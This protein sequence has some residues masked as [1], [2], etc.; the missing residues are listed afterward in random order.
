M[1]QLSHSQGEPRRQVD[2]GLGTVRSLNAN[3]LDLKRGIRDNCGPQA[4][5]QQGM[6]RDHRVPQMVRN[7]GM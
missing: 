1:A 2:Q 7:G 6:V 3:T 4:L 5:G